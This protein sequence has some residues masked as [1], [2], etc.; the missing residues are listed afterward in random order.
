MSIVPTNVSFEEWVRHIFAHPVERK[1]WYWAEDVDSEPYELDPVRLVAHTTHLC[2]QSA[3]VLAP[4]TDA[5]VD[6]GFWFLV[7]APSELHV[8]GADVVPLPDRLRCIRSI[9]ILFEQCFATRCTPHL[10][11]TLSH[12]DEPGIGPLNLSCY[13]WWDLLHGLIVM[14]QDS[15]LSHQITIYERPQDFNRNAI[16]EACISV[17]ESILEIPSVACQESAIHGLGHWGRFRQDRCHPVIMAFLERH[18]DVSPEL[19]PYA[20]KAQSPKG[21]L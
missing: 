10:S 14:H 2:E 17:M 6:Q 12:R 3:T 15:N 13:M 19:R 4:F 20:W 11:H 16:D 1:E 18:P 9:F 7:G 21:V 5:Q 8:L